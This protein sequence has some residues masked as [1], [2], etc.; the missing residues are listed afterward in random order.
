MCVL[1]LMQHKICIFNVYFIFFQLLFSVISYVPYQNVTE[2][3]IGLFPGCW[4]QA[5]TENAAPAFFILIIILLVL[6][7][8][9]Q[10]V[11]LGFSKTVKI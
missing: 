6:V 4:F 1:N 10:S 3:C 2:Y 9:G 7:E 8:I 5:K 11:S